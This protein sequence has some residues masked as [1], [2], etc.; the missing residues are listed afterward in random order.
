L[1][2]GSDETRGNSKFILDRHNNPTFAAAIEFGDDKASESKRVLKLACLT[3]RIAAGRR[4]D[5]QQGFVRRVRIE[6]A[7]SAFYLLQLG[8]QICFRVLA[9]GSVA[10]QKVDILLRCPL[11]R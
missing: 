4:I 9:A 8:H 2:A 1:F 5:Y 10:K 6:F 3:K 11:M 7:Q